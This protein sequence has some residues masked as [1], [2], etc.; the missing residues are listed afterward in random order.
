MFKPQI[1]ILEII[2]A[3]EITVIVLVLLLT[4]AAVLYGQSLRKKSGSIMLD[5]MLMGR[6]L[7]L[8]LFVATLAASWYGGVFGGK[9]ITFN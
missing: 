3:A 7:T 5:Y 2:T 9:K 4:V 1:N 8:P 6:R